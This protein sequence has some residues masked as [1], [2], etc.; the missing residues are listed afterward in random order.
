MST[1][2]PRPGRIDLV[3][4]AAVHVSSRK[5]EYE[6]AHPRFYVHGKDVLVV[7]TKYPAN[8]QVNWTTG[9]A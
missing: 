7:C 4:V 6:Y 5:G 2:V 9:T 1:V 3:A 8:Q